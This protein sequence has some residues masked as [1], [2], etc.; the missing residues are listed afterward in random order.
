MSKHQEYLPKFV[1][2]RNGDGTIGHISFKELE[3]HTEL[4]TNDNIFFALKDPVYTRQEIHEYETE[5][6][7]TWKKLKKLLRE[8]PDTV[9]ELDRTTRQYR[10]VSPTAP[11]TT[12]QKC[13]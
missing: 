7:T 6:N 11:A 8:H 9:L 2:I 13:L 1:N 4:I 3:R 5:A 12:K 10:P